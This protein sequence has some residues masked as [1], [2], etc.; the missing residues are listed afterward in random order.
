MKIDVNENGLVRLKEVCDKVEI[1]S[2]LKMKIDINENGLIRLS[3]IYSEIEIV[4]SSGDGLVIAER[5]GHF[6]FRLG[7]KWYTWDGKN[8]KRWATEAKLA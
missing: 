3:E 4:T 7:D 6:E 2:G 1:T 8:I 5:D